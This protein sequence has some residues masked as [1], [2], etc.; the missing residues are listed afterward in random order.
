[1]NS[2]RSMF[3][4]TPA[5]AL[6]TGNAPAALPP[7]FYPLLPP[8]PFAGSSLR[9][10][11]ADGLVAAG[12]Y[13]YRSGGTAGVRWT[14]AGVEL[15]EGLDLITAISADGSTYAGYR[16]RAFRTAVYF[17]PSTGLAEIGMLPGSDHPGSSATGVDPDGTMAVGFSFSGQGQEAFAWTLS[18]GLRALPA[19]DPGHTV[20]TAY[21]VTADR[22]CIVGF[23][24]D[25][26]GDRHAVRWVIDGPAVT[27]QRLEDL[28]GGRTDSAALAVSSDGSLI[29][30]Y[31]SAEEAVFAAA[32][33]GTQP[34]SLGDLPGGA[35]RSRAY[36][37]SSDGA[38]I[39]GE[40]AEA[41][42]PAAFIWSEGYG[43][44][45]LRTAMRMAGLP[46]PA[47]W[48]PQRAFG[49]SADGLTVVGEGL[50]E[51]GETQGYLVVLPVR[52]C[53]GDVNWDGLV[54]FLDYLAFLNYYGRADLAVDYT[55]DGQVDFGDYLAFLNA[56]TAGCPG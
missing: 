40:A 26:E 54:D 47:G 5:A 37:V 42:G 15:T 14:P 28:P 35:D 33:P 44:Q 48:R 8:A 9:T 11:S 32:W 13:R 52:P 22:A 53:G 4:I 55:N 29:V 16:D 20:S 41:D 2:V 18:A 23:C 36:A 31:A 10:V 30:G 43:M 24:D 25:A 39:A 56:Y 3:A 51:S 46:L 49:L 1:M 7:G 50:D 19:L 38:V 12:G 6:L 27:I 21:A 17:S 45:S 34:R